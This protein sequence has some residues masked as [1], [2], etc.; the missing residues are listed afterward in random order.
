MGH[1]EIKLGP[2]IKSK[3]ISK[4]K[5]CKNCDMQRTQLNK[6]INNEMERVDLSILSRLCHYLGCEVSEILEYIEE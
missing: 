2:L 5:I 6:Y 3:G 1:V 4:N